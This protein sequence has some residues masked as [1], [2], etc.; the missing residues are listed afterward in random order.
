MLGRDGLA[1][2]AVREVRV[3]LVHNG[4]RAGRA[5]SDEQVLRVW[6]HVGRDVGVA[7]DSIGLWPRPAWVEVLCGPYPDGELSNPD[8]VASAEEWGGVG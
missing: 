6:L 7:A 2:K 4:K 5:V 1:R 8:D 3:E